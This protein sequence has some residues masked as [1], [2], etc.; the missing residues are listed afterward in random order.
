[1]MS[2][3]EVR[4]RRRHVFSCVLLF[5]L[6]VIAPGHRVTARRSDM[7][8]HMFCHFAPALTRVSTDVS[9]A[10]AVTSSILFSFLCYKFV[11]R[12]VSSAVVSWWGC[13]NVVA[14]CRL[15]RPAFAENDN[16][17]TMGIVND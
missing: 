8:C 7:G 12:F 13:H 15:F 9:Q 11:F 1:M 3:T 14:F 4:H 2:E 5:L 6:C 17:I 10:R 16:L